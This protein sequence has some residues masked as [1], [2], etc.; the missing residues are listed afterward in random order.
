MGMI[1]H[2]HSPENNKFGMCLQYLKK[3]GRDEADFSHAEKHQNFLQ[4]DCNTLDIK[5]SYEMMLSLLVIMIKYSQISQGNKF[6]ISL[7]CLKKEVRDGVYF[8]QADKRQ[9][10]YKLALRGFQSCLLVL[11]KI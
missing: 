5:V 2:S 9:S 4:I 8:L 11:V 3:E 1:K 10:F 6:A 7:Q